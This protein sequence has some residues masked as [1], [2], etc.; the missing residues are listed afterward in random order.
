MSWRTTADHI[1]KLTHE[2]YLTEAGEHLRIG[3]LIVNACGGDPYY[4]ENDELIARLR[5][6]RKTPPTAG[7]KP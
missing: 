5:A 2:L 7:E 3:Q 6:Y 4:I 1:E